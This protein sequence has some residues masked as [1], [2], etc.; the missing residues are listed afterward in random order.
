MGNPTPPNAEIIEMHAG[1]VY[2]LHF[3]DKLHHAGHYVGSTP[4]PERRLRDHACGRGACLTAAL[5]EVDIDWT[6][7]AL[8]QCEATQMRQIEHYLKR[9]KNGPRHCP[10]CSEQLRPIKGAIRLR[11]EILPFPLTARELRQK[12][13]T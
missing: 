8:F 11:L 1:Y 6:L 3:L 13:S 10:L 4:D 12:D 7:A 2:V 5:L 9:R